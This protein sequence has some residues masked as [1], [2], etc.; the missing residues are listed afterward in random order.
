M[1]YN[2]LKE[3][4]KRIFHAGWTNF[5]RNSYLSLGTTGVMVLVLLLFSALVALNFLSL[6]IVTSLQEKVDVTAYF[7]A[8]ATEEE[9]IK[10]K[11]DLSK[12]PEVKDIEYISR[13]QALEEFKSRH[14]GDILIQDSLAELDENPLQPF[15]NIKAVNPSQYAEIVTFIEGNKFRTLIDKINFYENEQVID[16][17]ERISQGIQGWG[18]LLT[19]AMALVAILVTFNTVRLTIYNQ[20]QEI[21]IM[22]LVGGSDWHIRAP[23]LVEGGLYGVFAAAITLIIFYPI[24]YLVSSKVEML[25]PKASLTGYFAANAFQ[26][27]GLV[28]FVGIIL[29]VVSS[30]VAIRRFLKI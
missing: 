25:I 17:V 23:Y 27:V 5:Q 4:L 26:Y 8:E 14:A 1:N 19:A 29:G 10:V 30:A 7:K 13:D 24:I 21:E 12:R 16:R 15:L 28:L 20:R 2:Y 3:S 6:K 22:R 18:M 9:I 11:S